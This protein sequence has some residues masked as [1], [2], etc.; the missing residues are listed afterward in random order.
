MRWLDDNTLVYYDNQRITALDVKTGKTEILA[1]NCESISS[2]FKGKILFRRIDSR[3]AMQYVLYDNGEETVLF[4]SKDAEVL[5]EN[6]TLAGKL[7]FYEK[8]DLRDAQNTIYSIDPATG[9]EKF[10]ADGYIVGTSPDRTRLFYV[11][12]F[13]NFVFIP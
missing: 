4:K 5:R 8:R 13:E 9:N 10:V 2:V 11:D 3:G 6:F 12:R 7:L 1:E